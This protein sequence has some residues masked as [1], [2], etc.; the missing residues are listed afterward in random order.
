VNRVSQAIA[1]GA[2]AKITD[3]KITDR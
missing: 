3:L 2:L 1:G